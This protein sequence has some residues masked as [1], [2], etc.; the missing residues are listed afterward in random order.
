[1]ALENYFNDPSQDCLA[2]LFDAINSID[3]SKAPVL[4]RHE[5]LIMRTSERKDVFVEK[6]E[7]LLRPNNDSN[8]HISLKTNSTN[9]RHKATS[10]QGSHSSFEDGILRVN[11]K[12]N[13]NSA[14][15]STSHH[16]QPQ[17]PP[18]QPNQPS[19]SNDSFSLDGSAVWVGDESGLDQIGVSGLPANHAYSMGSGRGRR[20]TDASS[21]ASSSG[22]Q[23]GTKSVEA[24]LISTTAH[25]PAALKDTHFFPAVMEYNE[26]R[27]PIKLPMATF[28]EEVGDVR[29]PTSSFTIRTD[30]AK[31]IVLSDSTSPT[32]LRSQHCRIRSNASSPAYVWCTNTSYHYPLQCPRHR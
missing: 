1:M 20:S 4:T 9:S 28:P 29:L 12:K 13:S 21:S 14:A 25:D 24:N 7:D 8:A 11:T 15:S 3:I 18:Q 6:F 2:G 17:Q 32:L 30:L 23:G 27:I 16:S 10:S 22:F 26:H 19:P 31:H 5:K